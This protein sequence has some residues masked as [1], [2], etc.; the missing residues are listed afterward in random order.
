M[1]T[2]PVRTLQFQFSYH[3][4]ASAGVTLQVASPEVI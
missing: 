1:F 3:A 4:N 2:P